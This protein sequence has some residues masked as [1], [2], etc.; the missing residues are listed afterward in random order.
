[1]LPV[2]PS[3]GP[4]GLSPLALSSPVTWGWSCRHVGASAE[5]PAAWVGPSDACPG[6]HFSLTSSEPL[7]SCHTGVTA[8]RAS[9]SEPWLSAYP[10]FRLEA[11]QPERKRQ[12]TQ[13]YQLT[14]L[15]S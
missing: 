10:R 7:M 4:G 1:M 2:S 9:V 3:Q 14:L 5:G 12:Q 8:W 13:G 6:L 11:S 15:P